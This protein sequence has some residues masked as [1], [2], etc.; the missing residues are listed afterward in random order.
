MQPYLKV[1]ALGYVRNIAFDIC[2]HVLLFVFFK[3]GLDWLHVFES[4]MSLYET[5]KYDFLIY[6]GEHFNDKF[7]FLEVPFLVLS[8]K[9][10]LD[11][12]HIRLCSLEIPLDQFVMCPSYR[13]R[14]YLNDIPAYQLLAL[15]PKDALDFLIG[16][17]D[18][19]DAGGSSRD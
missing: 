7:N 9:I 3:L 13:T 15:K 1:Q 19:S 16:M 4:I 10:P 5:D 14:D 8:E 2:H 12:N 17:N 18:R 6:L 11:F